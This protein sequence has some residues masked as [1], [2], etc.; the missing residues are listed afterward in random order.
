M[1]ETSRYLAGRPRAGAGG[2]GGLPLEKERK[3][4]HRAVL[5]RPD[6]GPRE[7]KATHIFGSVV[8]FYRWTG[9]GKELPVVPTLQVRVRCMRGTFISDFPLL[10]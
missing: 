4:I 1:G 7:V 5:G 3:K 6:P 10:C 2:A 8:R 9:G